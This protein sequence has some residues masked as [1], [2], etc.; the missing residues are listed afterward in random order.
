MNLFVKHL[1]LPVCLLASFSLSAQ[2]DFQRQAALLF[3]SENYKAALPYYAQLVN[4]EPKSAEHNYRLGICYLHAG[5]TRISS[6][7]P[8]L[9]K[10]NASKK[11][12]PEYR[13]WLGKAYM[14][15]EEPEK[16]ITWLQKYKGDAATREDEDMYADRLISNCTSFMELKKH[17]VN[18]TFEN[19][20]Q[21]INSVHDDFNPFVSDNESFMIFNS[22]RGPESRVLT[23]GEM[24]T[25]IFIS[26]DLLGKWEVAKGIGTM[27]NQPERNEEVVGVAADGKTVVLAFST[28]S[29]K[30][31]LLVAPKEGE[32]FFEPQRLVKPVNSFKSETAAT[33]SPDGNTIYFVSDRE[34]TIGGLDI[35]RVTKLPTGEWS[36]PMN[37]GENINTKEDEDLPFIS[38]DGTK[39]FFSSE[40]HN[41]IG[42]FDVFV[43]ENDAEP[44]SW[45][46]AMN[47]GYPVNTPFDNRSF[48]ISE[49]G[50][51]GYLS[52][53]RNDSQ[54][55]LDIYR[56]IFN[57][58]E[59]K[60]TLIKGYVASAQGEPVSTRIRLD[61]HSGN[62]LVGTYIP[63]QYTGKYIMILE[64]GEYSVT[65]SAEGFQTINS[66][67]TVYDK[68]SFESE[69]INEIYLLDK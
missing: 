42:G 15:N 55:G 57:D 67:L 24:M 3:S 2:E 38:A 37:L 9:E 41:S 47:I 18:V 17:P 4:K 43:S 69:R 53:D 14:Y 20:G 23:N 16:A 54:G 66:S 56:V 8:Y 32:V 44:G 61:V 64:P 25:D 5:Y 7:L 22:N 48:C 19:A 40:G 33:L 31:D 27:I 11:A 39:L 49:T 63:N 30:G 12:L 35:F 13:L 62:K 65:V 26:R 28:D 46:K 50:R 36:E 59:P 34:G 58:V 21:A 68:S 1:L 45:K 29:L 6:A 51:Y 60:K 52:M 10:A